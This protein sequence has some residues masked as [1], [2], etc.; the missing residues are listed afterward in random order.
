ME[1]IQLEKIN[2][3]LITFTKS[4]FLKNE[5][6]QAFFIWNKILPQID[7]EVIDLVGK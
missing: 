6:N 4:D 5:I 1:S 3:E 2:K 7:Q